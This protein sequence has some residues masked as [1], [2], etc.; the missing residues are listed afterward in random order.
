MLALDEAQVL[1][2]GGAE[3]WAEV[4]YGRH[5]FDATAEMEKEHNR[6]PYDVRCHAMQIRKERYNRAKPESVV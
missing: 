2:E 4:R 5:R 6:T 3:A 1:R